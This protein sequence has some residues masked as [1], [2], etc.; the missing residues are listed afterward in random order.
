MTTVD[1]R[2]K[3]SLQ[4]DTGVF[5]AHVLTDITSDF[6]NGT[7]DLGID[8][9][10]ASAQITAKRWN[11]T[12]QHE[13]RLYVYYDGTLLFNGF[14]ADIKGGSGKA[15]QYVCQGIMSRLR[16]GWTNGDRTYINVTEQSVIQNLIEASGIDASLTSIA[17]TSWLIGVVNPVV[18]HGGLINPLTGD[19]GT[20]DVPLDLIRRIDE[21]TPL[22]V[23]YEGGNGA[24]TRRAWVNRS[25]VKNFDD[26][27]NAWNVAWIYSAK[28]LRNACKV[29]GATI[30]GLP[31]SSL[32]QVTNSLVFDPPKYKTHT[33]NNSL[34]EDQTHAD[35]VSNAY[36]TEENTQM[37]THTFTAP[38]DVDVQVADTVF[39]NFT[40]WGS[41][42]RVVHMKHDI[43]Q[44]K[45]VTNFTVMQRF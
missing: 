2:S 12:A 37:L 18:L 3:V 21:A 8:I 31:L 13:V 4:L 44:T 43:S 26:F 28:D 42:A 20:S 11:A 9:D 34:I 27:V 1:I 5:P 41:H 10:N 15:V 22:Y 19:P 40:D 23:T 45:A 30:A 25:S 36:V 32:N 7:I 39:C 35:F 29:T 33:V 14:I 17:G 38:I 24:V 6:I 16:V